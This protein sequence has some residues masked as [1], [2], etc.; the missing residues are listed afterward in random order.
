MPPLYLQVSIGGSGS[1]IFKGE[2]SLPL[3]VHTYVKTSSNGYV[4]NIA[5]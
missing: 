1:R 4:L 3:L 2:G 5:S